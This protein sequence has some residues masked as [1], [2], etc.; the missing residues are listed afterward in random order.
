MSLPKSILLALPLVLAGCSLINP[1]QV[2][3]PDAELAALL[4][5][6]LDNPDQSSGER[7]RVV[8]LVHRQAARHPS[9]V[10]TLMAGAA[11][12][13]E[14]GNAMR[15]ES[16][17]SRVLTL[18]TTHAEARMLRSQIAIRDGNLGLATELIA[19]GIDYRPDEPRLHEAAAWIEYLG[20][21]YE[22]AHAALD[23]AERLEAPIWRVSF[24]RGLIEERRGNHRAALRYYSACLDDRPGYPPAVSRR[25][26]L[27]AHR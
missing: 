15:A 19:E 25:V 2:R 6:I 16:L 11:L 7:E 20:G 10:P 22:A 18:D 13:W 27:E 23:R 9:H 24:N 17:V 3:D 21:N 1:E 4:D 14:D 12:A 5:H 26:G 8:A